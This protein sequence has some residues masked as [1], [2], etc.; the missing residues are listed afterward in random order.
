MAVAAGAPGRLGRMF[1]KYRVRRRGRRRGSDAG[2]LC[3][4]YPHCA[5]PSWIQRVCEKPDGAAGRDRRLRPGHSILFDLGWKWPRRRHRTRKPCWNAWCASRALPRFVWRH[6][7]EI[8]GREII[9]TSEF[10]IT[11]LGCTPRRSAGEMGR[12]SSRVLRS[13]ITRA[14]I[15]RSAYELALD[16]DGHFLGLRG[17]I[18]RNIGA[19]AA[20]FGPLRKTLGILSGVYR[21]P[22]VHLRGRCVFTHTVPTIAYRS[23]GRPEAIYVIER[24]IDLAA[25]RH[26]FD[27]IELRR[28]NF[29]PPAAMPYTNGVGITY[30]N[31]EYEKN[32]D[33][34][35][36]LADWKGFLARRRTRARASAAACGG[37]AWPITSKA[38]AARRANAP[39]S[40]S[41][42][43]VRSN[44][45]S[46]R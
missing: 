7:R 37:S 4:G 10:G 18:L 30:D 31:G 42:R 35:L 45:C 11:A 15:S 43:Q 2:G 33:T 25:D 21:I 12:R 28:R 36:G 40:Q 41:I 23:S 32:M 16:A 27:R 3:A 1:R 26:G 44:W 22:A 46:G 19:Y 17:N 14:A 8:S 24:L 38:P 39:R 34:A 9:S 5:F 6:G 13:A 29:I 20:H